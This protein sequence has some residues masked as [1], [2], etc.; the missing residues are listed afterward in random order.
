[1]DSPE[2]KDVAR[3]FDKVQITKSCWFWK[4][5]LSVN[6]YGLFWF[7][8]KYIRA[9]RFSYELFVGPIKDSKM[10][11]HKRECGNRNCINPHHLYMGTNA[12]NMR[13]MMLWG[14]ATNGQNNGSAKLSESDVL[15]IRRIHKNNRHGYAKSAELFGVSATTIGIVVRGLRWKHI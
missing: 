2:T 7:R 8:G 10:I 15:T 12:D 11:L 1:M 14:N 6:G 3:F 5:W 4:I 9:H 13:D